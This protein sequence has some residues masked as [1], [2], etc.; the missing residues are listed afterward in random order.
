MSE[1]NAITTNCGLVETDVVAFLHFLHEM[2]IVLWH[3][4]PGLREVVILDAV[5]YFVTPITVVICKHS[6]DREDGTNHSM[7]SHKEC[8]KMHSTEWEQ[9]TAKGVLTQVMLKI[10]WRAYSEHTDMLIRLMIKFGL[11]IHLHMVQPPSDD[12]SALVVN[13]DQ[14]KYLVPA[15]LPLAVLTSKDVIEWSDD[16]SVMTC[17]LVF[18][19]NDD[20]HR[21]TNILQ[22]D[23]IEKGFL[24]S[25]LFERIVG[26]AVMCCQNTS[27]SSEFNLDDMQLFRNMAV[28]S[29]GIQRFRLTLTDVNC[30]RVDIEGKNPLSVHERLMGLV[31]EVLDGCMKSLKCFSTVFYSSNGA[32]NE[33]TEADMRAFCCNL[34]V[35]EESPLLLIP[36]EQLRQVASTACSAMK[37]LGRRKLLSDTDIRMYYEPWLLLYDLREGYDVFLS[38]RWGDHDG[39]FVM[40]LFDMFTNFSKGHAKESVEVFLDKKRLKDGRPYDKDFAKALI[41]SVVIAP[42]VSVDALQRMTS[43]DSTQVDNLLVEW[44]LSI[45]CFNSD[46]CATEA[47]LPIAFGRRLTSEFE[48]STALCGSLFEADVLSKVLKTIPTASLQFA[49]NLI[50]ENNIEMSADAKA[51][52]MERTLQ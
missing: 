8:Q 16:S 44:I 36:L 20:L 37:K 25:G 41:N 11:L 52:F 12:T 17:M 40:D 33:V 9:L 14:T 10:L 35:G 5:S 19:L 34:S 2:G 21:N 42:V 15:L 46:Q 32:A 28:L 50:H 51:A 4:E 18:T 30:I 23:L 7:P 3:D 43:H 1:V 47:V 6:P 27:R 39:A 45:Y 22:K 48:S 49:L 31:Q 24:P 38:Y 13:S 29:F 26:K